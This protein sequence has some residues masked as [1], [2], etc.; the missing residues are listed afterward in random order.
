MGTDTERPTAVNDP[1]ERSLERRSPGRPDRRSLAIG[2]APASGRRAADY[3]LFGVRQLRQ[4]EL[5]PCP[6]CIFDHATLRYLAVNA[7]AHA[8][9]W[10]ES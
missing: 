5:S 9:P 1:E 4:F 8:R 10:S 7:A 3:P 2:A 6:M